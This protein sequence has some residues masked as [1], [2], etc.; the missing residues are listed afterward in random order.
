MQDWCFVTPS[1]WSHNPR[2]MVPKRDVRWTALTDGQFKMQRRAFLAAAAA[3]G[4]GM[5]VDTP[6]ADANTLWNPRNHNVLFDSTSGSF[7]PT[8]HLQDLLQHHRGTL[9]DRCIIAGEIHDRP[10][11][12]A[13]QLEV[14][15]SAA[16]LDQRPLVV[17]FEQFYR[18]HNPFLEQYSAGQIS[19]DA[20]LKVTHWS[21]TWGYDPELYTPLFRWCRVNKVQM[22]GLNVPRR[23]VSFVSQ[24]GLAGLSPELRTFLPSD[25]DTSDMAHFREFIKLIGLNAH[26]LDSRGSDMRETVWKWFESQVLWDEYMSDSVRLT[27][28]RIPDARVVALIGAGH[29]E[30]RVGFPNR[31]EKRLVERPLTIVP[32][33]VRWVVEE[34]FPMPDIDHPERNVSDI[35]WYTNRLVDNA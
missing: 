16:K 12:H 24:F 35:I 21:N 32:R 7:I 30:S 18:A 8:S 2:S 10:K 6:P 11:T 14:L 9:F 29:V 34:G 4:G 15:R 20:L 33:E 27:C 28:E 17:G 3:L 23:L 13:A 25:M 31:V 1:F 5:L 19:L 22:V 26:N